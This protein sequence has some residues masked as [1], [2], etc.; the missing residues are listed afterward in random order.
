VLNAGS[1]TEALRIAS[2]GNVGIGSTNPSAAKLVVGNNNTTIGIQAGSNTTFGDNLP[3]LKVMGY[4]GTGN[5]LGGG[6]IELG[7]GTGDSV[8]MFIGRSSANDFYIKTT[9]QNTHDLY[10][11]PKRNLIVDSGNVGIGT[12]SPSALLSLN[13]P[14]GSPSF[15]IGS[16]TATSFFVDKLGNV[17][18]G[19]AAPDAH[20][21]ITGADASQNYLSFYNNTYPGREMTINS[22]G[23]AWNLVT[24]PWAL[25][26]N[27]GSNSL[28][29]QGAVQVY[30][31]AMTFST[32]GGGSNA[33]GI[34]NTSADLVQL[35]SSNGALWHPGGFNIMSLNTNSGLVGIGTTSPYA[36]LHNLSSLLLLE[37]ELHLLIS[38]LLQMEM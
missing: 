14:A 16:S 37:L 4:D 33:F 7:D 2:S 25:T 3:N 19:T 34:N 12:T 24:N 36:R 31:G 22:T 28:T 15:A 29:L 38:S 23:G 9:G 18:I 21:T 13:A 5:R 6:G 1:T 8:N 11:T 30:Y 35:S 10:L 17:G 32:N 27:T 20:L 26:L